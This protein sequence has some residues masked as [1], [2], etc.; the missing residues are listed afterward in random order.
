MKIVLG[1]PSTDKMVILEKALIGKITYDSIEGVAADSE[2]SDQ[3]L[4]DEETSLGACNR[5]KN[6][7]K[8]SDAQLSFGL[9]GGLVEIENRLHLLCVAA[10]WDGKIVT[11]GSSKPLPLPLSVSNGVRENQQFGELIREYQQHANKQE[12]VL[13]NELVS[14]EQ[15]FIRAI[16]NALS[17]M[18]SL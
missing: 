9:E 11:F 4:S 6:A 12:Q 18:P 5:A 8:L 7:L 17:V 14:R 3:P 1:S 13:V 16:H 2:V 10:V 15:S